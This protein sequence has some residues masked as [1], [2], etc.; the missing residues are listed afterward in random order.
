MARRLRATYGKG[1]PGKKKE[2]GQGR[3]G[4]RWERGPGSVRDVGTRGSW[5][6]E[7]GLAQPPPRR[8]LE[9]KML[10]AVWP[11]GSPQSRGPSC[12][13][14]LCTHLMGQLGSRPGTEPLEKGEVFSGLQSQRK[15][16]TSF[17]PFY[18]SKTLQR[19]SRVALRPD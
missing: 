6:E 3:A 8:E 2:R 7:R 9:A 17:C 11:P 4:S 14:S 18:Q 19:D 12:P 5:Q 15:A 16:G 13:P 10:G 1:I